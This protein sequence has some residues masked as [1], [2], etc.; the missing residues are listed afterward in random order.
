MGRAAL[1]L[2]LLLA[3]AGAASA[4]TREFLEKA[5]AAYYSLQREGLIEFTC[6]VVPNWDH[7]LATPR[8][9]NPAAAARTHEMLSKTGFSVTVGP[10]KRATVAHTEVQ[11]ANEQQAKTLK[12]HASIEQT[13]SGSSCTRAVQPDLALRL[14]TY[15]LGRQPDH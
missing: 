4:D 6:E 12:G 10:G 1:A 2:C 14:L 3:R 9:L 7:S 11:P 5:R 15:D 8:R 13:C